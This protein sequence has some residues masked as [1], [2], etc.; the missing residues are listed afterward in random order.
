VH[1]L[2]TKLRPL[3]TICEEIDDLRIAAARAKIGMVFQ[4]YDLFAH[5]TALQNIIAAPVRVKRV[6]RGRAEARAREFLAMV[7]LSDNAAEHPVR[8]SG[9]Q[10][11]RVAIAR[12]LARDPKIMLFDE[13]TS[14]STPNLSA[15]YWR[16]CS[17]WRKT[18]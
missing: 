4:S 9:G 12:A 7:G 1:T 2:V 6:P 13:V 17:N 15:R 18:A 3:P 11:Q 10:E 16:Q 14:R 5:M 8:L